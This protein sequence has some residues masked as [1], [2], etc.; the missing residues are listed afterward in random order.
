MAV[1]AELEADAA[2]AIEALA[3][4]ERSRRP[5]HS[6]MEMYYS[7]GERLSTGPRCFYLS[8]ISPAVLIFHFSFLLTLRLTGYRR[9]KTST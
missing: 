5:Y 7:P 4:C 8:A 9:E 3:G 6:I 2:A 1:S